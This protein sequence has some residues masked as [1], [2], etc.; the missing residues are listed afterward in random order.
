MAE[1][2]RRA[3]C[4]PRRMGNYVFDQTWQRERDRLGALESLFD[5]ASRRLMSSFGLS[6]GWRCLEVGF[7][8]GGIAL[9]LADQVG[10]DGY[11]LATDIDTRFL[12]GHGLSNL[13][14]RRHDIVTGY[15]DE[16]WFDL[17]HA[18]AV[19]EHLP[20]RDSVLPA[21]A[22]SLKPGGWLLVEDADF[23]EP[24]ATLLA[25][26][27]SF[28]HGRDAAQRVFL[29]AATLFGAIGADPSYGRRLPSALGEAGLVDVA[30]E[31]H[32]PVVRGGTEVWTRGTLEQLADR[33][34]STG[35][36]TAEDIDLFL[37]A[38]AVP[39]TLYAPPFMVSAWGRRPG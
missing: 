16:D 31:I 14:V 19:L 37:S 36:A 23:G 13:E 6:A 39:S 33:I 18:R 24:A 2:R 17:V 15:L 35:L 32:A 28:A 20:A 22:A 4:Q 12:D 25:Q 30:A 10:A 34:I 29:A 3:D 26:H 38:T 7:G 21:L 1:T 5:G 9:W 8:A 11:V 27:L